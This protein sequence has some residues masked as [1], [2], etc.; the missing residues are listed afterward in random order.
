MTNDSLFSDIFFLSVLFQDSHRIAIIQFNNVKILTKEIIRSITIHFIQIF[1]T[2]TMATIDKREKNVLL[3]TL[4][5]LLM[6]P[7]TLRLR[8]RLFCAV[9][10]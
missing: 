4:I 10:H 5:W 1:A 3:G 9:F 2:E 7:T 6:L 8:L